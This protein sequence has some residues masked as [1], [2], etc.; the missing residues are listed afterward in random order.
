MAGAKIVGGVD[1]SFQAT[2]TF[3]L[4]FPEAEVWTERAED[5]DPDDVAARVGRVDLLLAS[6]ECTSHS[7]AKGSAPRCEISRGTAFQVIR[8]ARVLQP[9]WVIVENVPQMARWARFQEW[10]AG[11]HELGYQTC[12]AVL[13][14]QDYCTPQ[15]RKRLIIMCDKEVEPTLPPKARGP[16]RT[17]ASI[18]GIGESRTNPWPFRPVDSAGRAKATIDRAER[19]IKA[20]GPQSEFI[21]VYYGSDGAG[22]YQSLDRP[23]RTVTTLD[24][25]AYVRPNGHG[26]EMRMLQPPELAAAMGF[27][28]THQW[29]RCSR[30]DRIRLIGNAVCPPVMCAVVRHL[31]GQAVSTSAT[32]TLAGSDLITVASLGSLAQR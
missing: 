32:V 30:R 26:H 14:A 3:Q 22:G 4:N 27:P 6:P 5:I 24:R 16:K 12:H 31:T 21:V 20:F 19:A 11:I 13:D 7:V 29:V 2:E 23:L 9:R 28:P 15:S 25:F 17:V 18:L 8:Y 10:M 1:A